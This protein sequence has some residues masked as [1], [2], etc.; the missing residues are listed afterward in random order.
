MAISLDRSNSWGFEL[1][2]HLITC[3]LIRYEEALI[4]TAI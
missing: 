3:A 4:V 2:I 1:I